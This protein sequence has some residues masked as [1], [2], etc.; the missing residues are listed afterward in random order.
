MDKLILTI[1]SILTFLGI[2]TQNPTVLQ[3]PEGRQ[4]KVEIADTEEERIKGLSNRAYLEKGTGLLFVFDSP[5]RYGIWMKDMIFPIDILWLDKSYKVVDLKT[6]VSPKTFPTV[7][8]P[9][10]EAVYVLELNSG[11]IARLQLKTNSKLTSSQ[12]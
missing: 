9:K 3:T 1:L 5:G 2:T 12:K 11:E 7:F 6:N 4:I 10:T 8:N